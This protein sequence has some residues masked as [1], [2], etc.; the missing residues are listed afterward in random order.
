MIIVNHQTKQKNIELLGNSKF[1]RVDLNLGSNVT[2]TSYMQDTSPSSTVISLGN[3]HNV[4][5][6]TED[7][8]AYCWRDTDGFQKF[9]TFGPDWHLLNLTSAQGRRLCE[10]ERKTVK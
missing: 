2:G 8:V 6:S 3:S 5:A 7:Y 10:R 9:G 1:I 4:N